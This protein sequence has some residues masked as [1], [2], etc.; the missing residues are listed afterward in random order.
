MSSMQNMKS[1]LWADRLNVVEAPTTSPIACGDKIILPARVVESLGERAFNTSA[2]LLIR[3]AARKTGGQF[4]FG[5]VLEFASE[6]NTAVLPAWMLKH[7]GV[8]GGGQVEIAI[9][10]EELPKATFVSLQPLD[11]HFFS[12]KDF[13]AVL[14][15]AI[16]SRYATLMK[17][18]TIM[19]NHFGEPFSV[20]VKDLAPDD[21]CSIV[22]TEVEVD[23]VCLPMFCCLL[24]SVRT[25][26]A[27]S[28]ALYA[29]HRSMIRFVY[30]HG[31]MCDGSTLCAMSGC[32]V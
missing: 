4:C 32:S 25:L 21:A 7:L 20:T 11:P 28:N 23:L 2:P 22:D 29:K 14:E 26:E 6:A 12:F 24:N 19:I 18:T 17:G 8:I 31:L 27:H 3:I 9:L 10:S 13:R 5:T 15:S 16:G 1:V 30:V